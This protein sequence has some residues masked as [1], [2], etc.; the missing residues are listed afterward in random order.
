M[1]DKRE[2]IPT[3]KSFEASADRK[4]SALARTLSDDKKSEEKE[5]R[6][7]LVSVWNQLRRSRFDL[8]RTLWGYKELYREAKAKQSKANRKAKGRV[9]K[10]DNLSENSP[11]RFSQVC[12][13]IGVDE[14]QANRLIEDYAEA[15]KVGEATRNIA[16]ERGIDLAEKKYRPVLNAINDRSSVQHPDHDKPVAEIVEAAI[17]AVAAIPKKPVAGVST[18][19]APSKISVAS[20]MS[21]REAIVAA[22]N[23]RVEDGDEALDELFGVIEKWLREH[24]FEEA[25][26]EA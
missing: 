1:N 19:P 6:K 8:G 10:S 12:G 22:L 3:L 23:V 2:E 25:A 21:K 20:R 9:Q 13:A 16:L 15:S 11:S 5:L 4:L 7:N 26:M 24:P 17:A 14:R 18:A